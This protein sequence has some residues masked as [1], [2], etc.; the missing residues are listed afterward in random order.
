MLKKEFEDRTHIYVSQSEYDGIELLYLE[1]PSLGKDEF[2]RDYHLHSGSL[3]IKDLIT[4]L[5]TF[6]NELDCY[7][8]CINK[9]LLVVSEAIK[10]KDAKEMNDKLLYLLNI[11]LKAQKCI[12]LCFFFG[13]LDRVGS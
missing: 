9:A 6:D 1:C 13:F 7:N 11:L 2:C 10:S 3:I 4:T 8:K 5:K 12:I